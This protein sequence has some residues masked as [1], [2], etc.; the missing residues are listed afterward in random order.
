MLP[1]EAEWL[2]AYFRK[3]P[4]EELGV[5]L[6]LGSSTASFRKQ[7]Q[8]FIHERVFEPLERRGV[9]VVHVDIKDEDGETLQA[10]ITRDADLDRLRALGARVVLCSNLLE[11]VPSAAAMAAC[12]SRLV[13]P[14]GTLV[15]T[16][17]HS[18]PYHPDPI[19]TRFRPDLDT[20]RCLFPELVAVEGAIVEAPSLLDEFRRRPP[21]LLYR[22]GRTFVPWPRF[23]A[24]LSALDRWRWLFRPYKVAC[25]V[26]QRPCATGLEPEQR[27]P[28]EAAFA[29][30][31]GAPTG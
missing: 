9:R 1:R 12:L 23:G 27:P 16:V 14:G 15:L 25:L 11:H 6:N 8:P 24:W 10:D 7:A 22:L 20:L 5:V 4:D 28:H 17:P 31:A 26:L 3:R 29:S 30:A 2:N 21:Q 13:P 19:D 18:Y